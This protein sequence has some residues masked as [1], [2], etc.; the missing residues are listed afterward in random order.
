MAIA[1]SLEKDTIKTKSGKDLE[2]VFIKHA[3]LKFVFE[4]RNIY[5]DPVSDFCNYNDMPKA[6]IIIYTHDHY[7]H[8]DTKALD[9]LRKKETIIISNESVGKEV[10]GAV[11]MKNGDK[12]SPATYVDIEAVAS[13]NTPEREQFHPRNGANNGYILTFDGLR[14][15]IA[16]DCEPM[17]EMHNF[18]SIDIAFLPVNQP[19]TMTPVQASDAAKI[20]KPAI[21]YPYHTGDTPIR[22]LDL[23]LEGSG[24]EIRYRSME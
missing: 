11:V 3:S 10:K 2:I 1:Q 4:G 5:I 14:V 21:F 22:E 24:I 6:D 17:D 16:G 9:A 7:D 8:Y 20:I 23:L 12:I 13:Y 19:Y 15:Y 18:G